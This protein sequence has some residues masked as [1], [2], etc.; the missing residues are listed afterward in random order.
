M[1][2]ALVYGLLY[3]WFK[4]FAIGFIEVYGF[5][6]GKEGLLFLGIFVGAFIVKLPFFWYLHQIQEP[7]FNDNGEIKLKL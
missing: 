2:I 6:L 4:S 5:N 1:Y 3:I 7:Q